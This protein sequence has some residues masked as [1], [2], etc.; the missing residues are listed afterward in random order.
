MEESGYLLPKYNKEKIYNPYRCPN[1]YKILRI[2]IFNED[3]II[4][5]T[6]QCKKDWY[7][8]YKIDESTTIIKPR[9]FD[10]IFN[11]NCSECNQHT[12]LEFKYMSKCLSCK[13]LFCNR[14]KCKEKHVHNTAKNL[15]YYDITCA[16]HSKEFIVY[17]KT[18]DKDLCELCIINEK[19]MNNTNHD[20]IYYKDIMPPKDKYI[21]KYNNF[22]K[23]SE[24]A[25]TQFKGVPRKTNVR[26]I[27]FFHLREIIRNC[28]INFSRYSKIN[29]FNFALISNIL[30]NS[31]F[32]TSPSNA[33][34]ILD[35]KYAPTCFL[36]SSKYFFSF[37]EDKINEKI[38]LLR[39][40]NN[41]YKNDEN[42]FV[43]HIYSS[44]PNKTLFIIQTS[45]LYLYDSQTF[46]QIYIIGNY[47]I[48]NPYNFEDNLLI[49]NSTKRKNSF[50][51][52]E[53]NKKEKYEIQV[54]LF[55][56]DYDKIYLFK[57]S[58][59]I[60][61]KNKL[62]IYDKNFEINKT[63]D[64]LSNNQSNVKE[65]TC[66]SDCIVY[67]KNNE[68]ILYEVSTKKNDTINFLFG[69]MRSLSIDKLDNKHIILKC[70]NF[71][72][73]LYY[74]VNVPL[75]QIVN[76]YCFG[77]RYESKIVNEYI[78]L[79]KKNSDEILFMNPVTSKI[80][81]KF[82]NIESNS[83]LHGKKKETKKETKI[84][85]LNIYIIFYVENKIISIFRF[86]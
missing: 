49:C 62:F 22:N 3:N 18:C 17:C 19:K 74:V 41:N 29:K 32:I 71:S 52:I 56:K 27:Y 1:C 61:L 43:K 72:F 8:S 30:E 6:C 15:I 67:F 13:K 2:K 45:K 16:I 77:L 25:V 59:I 51:L 44:F 79:S 4:K 5:Y 53:M 73:T 63:L 39:N 78:I 50:R 36:N 60:R 57:K 10:H 42:S 54:H 68:L 48:D 82:Y 35:Y 84:I 65:I 14:K 37:L 70:E 31:D 69:Y 9:K 83:Y 7:I 86:K 55:N 20:I 33:K 12:N 75:K 76:K 80:K 24:F 58:F 85:I 66:V 23:V 46:E 11:L 34:I 21:E 40:V 26:L 38:N 81:K 47:Q 28:F 64:L